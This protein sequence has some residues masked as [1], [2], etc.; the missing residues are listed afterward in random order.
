[1]AHAWDAGGTETVAEVIARAGRE[2]N[3]QHLW[4]IVGD[5]AN[6][7]PATDRTAKTLA[8]IKRT[9]STISMLV[10]KNVPETNLQGVL[11]VDAEA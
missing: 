8:A 10:V 7:L 9:S 11:F 2:A 6:H 5:L 1:M 3:D 4:A